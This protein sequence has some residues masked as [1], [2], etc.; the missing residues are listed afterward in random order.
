MDVGDRV[1]KDDVPGTV[2]GMGDG[3]DAIDLMLDNGRQTFVRHLRTAGHRI[4]FL[5]GPLTDTEK[6][7]ARHALGLPNPKAQSYRN[8]YVAALGSST[9]D[10]WRSMAARQFAT[11]VRVGCFRLTFAGA[12]AALFPGETLDREDF[13]EAGP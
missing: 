9:L 2:I 10:H 3:E 7:L 8:W 1:L 12:C 4:K 13:P 5:G 11:E 6:M